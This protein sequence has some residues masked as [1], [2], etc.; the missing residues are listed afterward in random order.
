MDEVIEHHH[1]SLTGIVWYGIY[2]WYSSDFHIRCRLVDE[3]IH[4]ILLLHTCLYY[5]VYI[6]MASNY[7][8]LTVSAVNE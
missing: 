6:S 1:L 7:G 2:V 3:Y 4:P 8:S 5:N